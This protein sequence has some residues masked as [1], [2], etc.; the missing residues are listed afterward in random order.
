[1][2]FRDPLP[3]F[4]DSLA[5]GVLVPQLGCNTPEGDILTALAGDVLGAVKLA[6]CG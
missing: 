6:F 3:P 4:F 1:L 5:E 2:T